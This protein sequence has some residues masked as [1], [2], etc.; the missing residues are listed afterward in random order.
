[1]L[2]ALRKH[3]LPTTVIAFKYP[4]KTGLD[5]PANREQSNCLRLPKPNMPPTDQQPHGDASTAR[6]KTRE[7]LSLE[8][9]CFL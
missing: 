5:L 2:N 6:S 7:T 4:S 3:Y 1:M 8:E 9:W